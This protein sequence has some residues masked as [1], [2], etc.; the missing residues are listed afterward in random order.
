MGDQGARDRAPDRGDA[1]SRHG[2]VPHRIARADQRRLPAVR[3][4]ARRHADK[5]PLREFYEELVKTQ[6][7]INRKFMGWRTAA[8]VSKILAGQLVRGQTNFLK[9]LFKFSK[10]YNVD[11]FHADHFGGRQVRDA[12]P[13]GL[14]SQA[15]AQELLVHERTVTLTYPRGPKSDDAFVQPLAAASRR[16]S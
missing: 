2:A 13:G 12:P 8:A 1:L 6:E 15:Q 7:I 10:V 16:S 11:R 5:L 3:H 4:P 14:P 9:M